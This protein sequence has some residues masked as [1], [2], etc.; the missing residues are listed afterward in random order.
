[1]K[2]CAEIGY[3]SIVVMQ[4]SADKPQKPS[5][6]RVICIGRNPKVTLIRLAVLVVVLPFTFTVILRPVHVQGISMVPTYRDRQIKFINRLAYL[7][8]EPRRGDVVV[9]RY[10]SEKVMLLKR[11]IGMPGETIAFHRGRAIINGEVLDEPYINFQK[12]PC[13]WEIAPRQ[14]GPN[15][16]YVVGDNRMMPEANHEKG[17]APRVRIAGRI[18]L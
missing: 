11:I 2:L 1:V 3:K 16:Y 13:D 15:E 10:S 14:I 12:F 7:F 17:L 8:S 5:W 9:V 4:P 6:L 18:F